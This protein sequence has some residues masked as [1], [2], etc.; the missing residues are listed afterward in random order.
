MPCGVDVR[1]SWPIDKGNVS[2][3]TPSL[4]VCNERGPHPVGE[5][6]CSYDIVSWSGSRTLG[7][8]DDEEKLMR[9]GSGG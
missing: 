5:M 6:L 8:G 9:K 1:L 3:G 7:A 4:D 2:C